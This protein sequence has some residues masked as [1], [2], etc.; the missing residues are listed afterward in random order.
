M[1]NLQ[2]AFTEYLSLRR[3]LGYKLRDEGTALYQFIQFVE[4]E[5]ASYITVD[6]A[7]RWAM[8]PTDVDPAHWARRLSMVRQF[9][10]YQAAEDPLTE[11]P[12]QGLL[13]YRYY[14]KQPYIYSDEEIVQLIKAAK[15]LDSPT[16]IR[17]ATYS[18]LFGL[19]A[20]TGMRISEAINIDREDV[21]LINNALIIRGAKCDKSRMIPIHLSTHHALRQYVCHQD[22]IYPSPKSPALFISERGVRLTG[23]SVR[24]TFIRLS[25]QIGLRGPFDS[26]GPRLHDFRYPNLNKIQT[27]LESA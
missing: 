12:P 24:W 10:K 14:R 6:L 23:C 5:G 19:L 7:L 2:T 22:R 1:S 26:H 18:T 9:A 20:V 25:R 11:I 27:F 13:P 16:G 21:D 4:Q 17:A 3:A 15:Q 8:K